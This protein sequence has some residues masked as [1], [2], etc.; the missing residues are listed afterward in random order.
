MYVFRER[1]RE[2]FWG[3][4]VSKLTGKFQGIFKDNLIF[5]PIWMHDAQILP[6]T[7]NFHSNSRNL[8]W[9]QRTSQKGE[10]GMAKMHSNF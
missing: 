6:V 1:E 5:L 4:F 8:H 10:F 2:L 7:F 9:K 3:F